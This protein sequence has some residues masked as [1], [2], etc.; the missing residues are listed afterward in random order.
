ML[1]I[2]PH[3]MVK[4]GQ[5]EI[6]YDPSNET[7]HIFGKIKVGILIATKT[8]DFDEHE[9]L[10][11]DLMKSVAFWEGRKETLEDVSFEV[12]SNKGDYAVITFMHKNGDSGFA[13][14]GLTEEYAKFKRLTVRANYAGKY[15]DVEAALV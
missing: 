8:I 6:S 7:I 5:F 3:G 13:E 15:F 12:V 14:L 4:G 1:K 11:R 10:S 9:H 2:I